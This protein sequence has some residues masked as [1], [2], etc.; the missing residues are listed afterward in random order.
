[1]PLDVDQWARCNGHNDDVWVFLVINAN[2]WF[3]K[4]VGSPRGVLRQ[5]QYGFT[6]GGPV[7]RNK[8]LMF[9]SWQGTKQSNGID[10]VSDKIDQLPPLTND[11]SSAGLGKIFGGDEGYLYAAYYPYLGAY[12]NQV[13]NA[14]GSNI[15]PQALACSTLTAEWSIHD[16]ESADDRH[17][18]TA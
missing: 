8:F 1:M 18:Q 9:G 14:D 16:S 3:T 6:A 11:R 5:N 17:F 13:I 4:A 15:A 12:D 10:P 2:G 7:V